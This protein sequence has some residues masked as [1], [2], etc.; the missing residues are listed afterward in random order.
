MSEE[1]PSI[2]QEVQK[3]LA[4][5]KVTKGSIQHVIEISEAYTK[6]VKEG[7]ADKPLFTPEEVEKIKEAAK[8]GKKPI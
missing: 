8:G 6:A 5:I 7:V 3:K 2:E 1:K 4:K